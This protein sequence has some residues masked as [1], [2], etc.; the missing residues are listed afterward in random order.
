MEERTIKR[1]TS[2]GNDKCDHTGATTASIPGISS[3]CS[4]GPQ[5]PTRGASRGSSNGRNGLKEWPGGLANGKPPI[6]TNKHVTN[7]ELI[8]RVVPGCFIWTSLNTSK[9]Q[10]PDCHAWEIYPATLEEAV[11]QYL[12]H[13]T[14]FNIGNKYTLNK[15]VPQKKT[16]LWL[17]LCLSIGPKIYRFFF[18]YLMIIGVDYPSPDKPI[19]NINSFI[20]PS[21]SPA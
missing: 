12:T 19:C 7:H 6:F 11:Y 1:K 8:M 9:R 2:S 20:N 16:N 18:H 3:R 17:W 4:S 13:H 5:V 14:T 10:F 15:V 21:I